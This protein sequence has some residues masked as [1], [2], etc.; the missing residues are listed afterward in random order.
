MCMYFNTNVFWSNLGS[1]KTGQEKITI[2]NSSQWIWARN[3]SVWLRHTWNWNDTDCCS[4]RLYI[5]IRF[6]IEVYSDIDYNGGLLIWQQC[7]WWMWTSDVPSCIS[8]L[9]N[10]YKVFIKPLN[11]SG[12]LRYWDI[13]L[14]RY[15]YPRYK[16]WF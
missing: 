10:I 5:Y 15:W 4:P 1:N 13:R 8:S 14:L 9:S 12:L 2:R 6:A 16:H 7:W 11:A 3:T